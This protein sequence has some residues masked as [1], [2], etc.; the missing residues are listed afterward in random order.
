MIVDVVIIA[1]EHDPQPCS[2]VNAGGGHPWQLSHEPLTYGPGC[3]G[4]R[5]SC[6]SCM[7]FLRYGC[8]VLACFGPFKRYQGLAFA[9]G[10]L[11]VFIADTCETC[12][13]T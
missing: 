6:P 1:H 3:S 13:E 2:A 10:R 4:Y 5:R 8:F 11:Y 7:L 9:P 12:R